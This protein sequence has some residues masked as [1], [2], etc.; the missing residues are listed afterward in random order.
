MSATAASPLPRLCRLSDLLTEWAQDAQAAETA[1]VTNTPRGPRTGLPSL[2][3]ALGG[4]LAP[5]LHIVTGSP[6]AGKTAFALQVAATC[7]YPALYV[8]TEMGALALF[9][10]VT[11]RVTGTF[12]GRFTDGSLATST[13]LGLAHRAAAAAGD[14]AIADSTTAAADAGWLEMAATGVRGSASGLLLVVDSAH[15]WAARCLPATPEYERLNVAISA[16]TSLAQ[17]LGAPLL[18]LAERNRSSMSGG[19]LNAAA[20]SRAFE[21]SGDSVLSLDRKDLQP[22]LN[23]E[24]P[25]EIKLDKNRNGA[26]GTCV[27]L[28]FSGRLQQFREE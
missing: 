4:F 18:V 28:K 15:S 23:D 1:Q 26:A 16:L 27:K 2:D 20:G 10:R 12:L 8:T 22:D 5:G 25:V 24:V 9:R 6:G 21:Y 7:G 13:S 17:K 14:L 11:A 3:R 19:G